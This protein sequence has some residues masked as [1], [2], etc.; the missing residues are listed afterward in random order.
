MN[1]QAAEAGVSVS[2]GARQHPDPFRAKQGI[3]PLLVTGPA[4]SGT[5]LVARLLSAHDQVDMAV[6]PL[7]PLVRAARNVLTRDTP[8]PPAPSAPLQDCYGS[9]ERAA[10]FRAMLDGDLRVPLAA[11]ALD[12]VRPAIARRCAYESP[13]L[14]DLAEGLRGESVAEALEIFLVG[15]KQ[16]RGSSDDALVGLKEVWAADLVPAFLRAF[17]GARAVLVRRDPR[18]VLASNLAMARQD[19]GQVAHPLSV[20]R[21]W[22]KQEAVCAWLACRPDLGERAFVM[23]YENLLADPHAVLAELCAFL[24]IEADVGMTDP[25]RVRDAEGKEFVANTSFEAPGAGLVPEL[26]NRWRTALPPARGE[27]TEFICGAEMIAAGYA[28]EY[29]EEDQ[30]LPFR[31]LAQ[32]VD[33]HRTSWSWRSDVEAPALDLGLEL[34][35]RGALTTGRDLDADLEAALFLVPEA[36]RALS[37]SVVPACPDVH[38]VESHPRARTSPSRRA[39]ESE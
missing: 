19:P 24:G 22:R 34:V 21:H 6:D 15:V 14:V 10:W 2:D 26:A 1:H 16:R 8:M 9:S 30:D 33:D 23:S 5:T 28:C 17:P 3:A 20:L 7:L 35:R 25:R 13:D 39:Q 31:V 38:P 29:G 4:R 18:A 12:E 36:R 27:L 11:G 37:G 32:I